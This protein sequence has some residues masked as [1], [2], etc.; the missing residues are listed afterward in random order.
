MNSDFLYLII[1]LTVYILVVHYAIKKDKPLLG[2]VLMVIFTILIL[3]YM[4]QFITNTLQK[5]Y[6]SSQNIPKIEN[7]DDKTTVTYFY[8]ITS[9]TIITLL[10]ST[11]YVFV[12]YGASYGIL[13]I[14]IGFIAVLPAMLLNTVSMLAGINMY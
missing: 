2:S 9:V 12:K 6:N 3:S 10:A 1:T 14:V 11:I 8:L 13:S 7:F 5:R 4:P